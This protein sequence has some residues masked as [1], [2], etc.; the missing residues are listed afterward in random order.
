MSCVILVLPPLAL[1]WPVLEKLARTAARGLAG[2]DGRARRRSRATAVVEGARVEGVGVTR[3]ALGEV[4]VA[5]RAGGGRLR[6]EATSCRLSQAEL[7][8]LLG[9]LVG[10]MRQRHAYETALSAARA[11]G[12][13]L[14]AESVDGE[15]NIRLLVGEAGA[16]H[17]AG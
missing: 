15:G 14:L 4:T 17:G 5:I 7:A 10:R 12:Y 16:G 3:L 1:A 11:Q 6:L 13:A 9:R 2:T 8:A